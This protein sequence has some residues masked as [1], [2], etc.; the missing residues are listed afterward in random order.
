M[1][2]LFDN[3]DLE[4]SEENLIEIPTG[5]EEKEAEKDTNSS[6]E[7]DKP[8]G[9]DNPPEEDENL[10][11]I[12]T[13][14]K[15]KG[16][17]D[18]DEGKNSSK[19]SNQQ[20]SSSSPYVT[21]ASALAE[22][23]II[24]KNS[25]EGLEEVEEEEQLDKV[26]E[27]INKE[28]ENGVEGFVDSLDPRLKNIM[29]NYRSGVSVEDI[30]DIEKDRDL[31]DQVKDESVFE[32][33]E[34]LAEQFYR[35]SMKEKGFSEDKIDR[36][37]NRAKELGEISQ[38]GKD[39]YNE[40]KKIHEQKE[41]QRK[42]DAAQAEKDRQEQVKNKLEKLEKNVSNTD[43]IIKGIKVNDNTKKELYE[44]LTKPVAF[45]ENDK[46]VSYVN[47][48]R[49]EDPFEFD[50]RLAYFAMQG[51]FDKEFDFGNVKNTAT[52]K[53]TTELKEKLRNESEGFRGNGGSQER[54]LNTEET[55]DWNKALENF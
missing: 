10:I 1:E 3:V 15:N 55:P 23:G 24:N 32:D 5:K 21:F 30:I 34:D 50:K 17:D 7:N 29:E 2:N 43:E 13:G 44:K 49:K 42:K 47:S 26:F 14:D 20:G 52:T 28:I 8:E 18:K 27:S 11:D 35:Q 6:K 9:G 12:E 48:V 51:F 40:F 4:S 37:V 46:P 19:S 53:A 38:E 39:S 54:E 25:L 33:N 45:D 22:R 36:H 41:E 16:V 31:I